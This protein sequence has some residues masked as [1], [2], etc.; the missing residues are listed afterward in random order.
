MAPEILYCA[1]NRKK[2]YDAAKADIF[3]LGV[4]LFSLVFEQYP[5]ERALSSDTN[6]K[7]L[8]KKQFGTF[9]SYFEM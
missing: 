3:A 5:F 6:F 7:Y 8:K 9:W 1:K 4:V 2:E